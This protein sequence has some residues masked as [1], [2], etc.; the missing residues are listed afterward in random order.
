MAYTIRGRG[1]K[2]PTKLLSNALLYNMGLTHYT[3]Q[4]TIYLVERPN[5]VPILTTQLATGQPSCSNAYGI[6]VEVSYFV[7]NTKALLCSL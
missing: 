6:G 3:L 7:L 2:A 4:V 5:N 1:N